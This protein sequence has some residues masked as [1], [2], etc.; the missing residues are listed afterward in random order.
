MT[1]NIRYVL[2]VIEEVLLRNDK[3]AED[4]AAI[5]SALRGPDEDSAQTRKKV[6]TARIRAQAFPRLAQQIVNEVSKEQAFWYP[7]S[8]PKVTSGHSRVWFIN[9][10]GLPI[11]VRDYSPDLAPH[12]EIHVR[13]AAEALSR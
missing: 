1:P 5:L 2:D 6:T 10:D 3:T 4:L 11:D 7:L 8:S 13:Q 9:M 12:F